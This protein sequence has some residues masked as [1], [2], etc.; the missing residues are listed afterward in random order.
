MNNSKN[1]LPK[2]KDW[3]CVIN[4]DEYKSTGT[5]WITLFVNGDNGSAYYHAAYFDNLGVKH[6]PK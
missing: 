6:I 5:H 4:L 2:V 3:V 1:I